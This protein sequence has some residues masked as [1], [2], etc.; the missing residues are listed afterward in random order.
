MTPPLTSRIGRRGVLAALALGLGLSVSAAPDALAQGASLEYPVKA[1]Y[2]AKFAPFVDWPPGALAS[3]ASPF[4]ICVVG[5]DPFGVLLDRAVAGQ[6]IGAHPIVARRL[7]RAEDATGC[8][9]LYIV[10]SKEQ[11]VVDAL[12]TL[13]GAPVLTV[14]DQAHG[15]AQGV[16][17]FVIRENRVRFYIDADSA[18]QNGLKISSKLLS[19]AARR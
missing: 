17:H 13:R 5:R 9:V 6:K 7:P 15:D 4:N 8:Q 14:T 2:L 10:G 3:D 16:I 11:P 18:S 1:A 12:R 19:L